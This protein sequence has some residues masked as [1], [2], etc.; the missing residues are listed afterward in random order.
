MS[1]KMKRTK[2]LI[3]SIVL[4]ILLYIILK[5]L[6][7]YIDD[8]FM[9]NEIYN[10]EYG[11]GNVFKTD[12]YND[13]EKKNTEYFTSESNKYKMSVKNY[14]H[15][16][17]QGDKDANYE[18]QMLYDEENKIKAAFML[19]V[20]E[21]R[22]STINDY[23]EDSNYYEFNHFPLYISDILRNQFLKNNNINNDV[24]LVKF[25]R[26]RKKI[27]SNFF[28][29]IY[30]MK[31]N[32]FFNFIETTLPELTSVTYIE[33]E[34]EGIIYESENYK[35]ACIIKKDKLYCLTFYKLDYFTDEM[36]YDT[37]NS[38]IIEK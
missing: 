19:G 14:F 31:E 21:T 13:E 30:K 36:I 12:L 22:L 9:S 28:T 15:G 37:I 25:I 29:P 4:Y 38:L 27:N 7:V 2:F 23:N 18:Y 34:L 20:F 35:Q 26:Q 16:F 6:L 3:I 17:E 10:N 8:L 1:G 24:D 11:L 32:Y 5:L 33:G